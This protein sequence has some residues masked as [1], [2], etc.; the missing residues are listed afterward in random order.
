[1]QTWQIIK[2]KTFH[3]NN[4]NLILE[5]SPEMQIYHINITLN[6][7]DSE[8]SIFGIFLDI[9][10]ATAKFDSIKL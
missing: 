2:S 9:E 5:F 8:H 4:I 7:H 6:N 3:H 1:M 10:S